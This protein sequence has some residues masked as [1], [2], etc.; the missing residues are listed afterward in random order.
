[1]KKKSRQPW[2]S[3]YIRLSCLLIVLRE[4]VKQRQNDEFI[5]LHVY[6]KT[7]L[8]LIGENLILDVL[9]DHK[10]FTVNVYILRVT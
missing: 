3:K 4:R 1:M 2:E 9:V 8:F 6:I 10:V 7:K 5:I